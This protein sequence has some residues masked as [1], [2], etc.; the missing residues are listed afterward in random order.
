M[1]KYKGTILIVD[2]DRDV[3]VTARI[4][5][6]D[7]FQSIIVES[8]PKRIPT[9][10]KNEEVY[11]VVLDMNFKPGATSGEE[12]ILWLKKIKE[13]DPG[14]S[15]VMNTAY[16]DIPLAVDAMKHGACEFIVKPWE[17][18]KLVATIK[19]A[20]ELSLSKRE[21]KHLK[22]T[23]KVLS[24]E[25]N[26]E[27]S[28]IFSVSKE[29]KAVFSMINK[30]A[31]TEANVLVLGENGTGKE[32]VAREIHNKSER[33]NKPFINVD[34]GAISTNLFESELFGHEKG[35]FT[36]AKED[37]LGRF[38]IASGGTLFLDEIGNLP[39]ALQ[40][41][42]LSVIQN[43]TINKVGSTKNIETDIRLICATNNDLYS[44]VEKG[45]FRQD[46]L[47]RINTVEINIPPLRERKGDIKLLAEKFLL[48]YSNKYNKPNLKISAKSFS[49]LENY[50]WPGNIRELQHLIE[51]AVILAEEK[52]LHE[53]DF[54]LKPNIK[55]LNSESLKVDE[56][57]KVAIV[58]AIQKHKG[59]LTK[60]SEELGFGRSTLYRKIKKYGI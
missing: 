16:G 11:V 39:V 10:L 22:N 54:A 28:E 34:L 43:K 48:K 57:E 60:A 14:I 15:V 37:K 47:Y 20:Y 12:G 30:V 26:K 45:E 17:C 27:Y 36:D 52:V 5:L 19:T 33:T 8:D 53:N 58:N 23:Q 46:L 51:R 49:A 50:S 25:L 18:A 24:S 44:M 35:A 42:L 2:D 59:N 3:L 31:K 6:K 41:K 4:V 40:S 7:A 1:T 32:L 29:M 9:I 56:L 38:E 13:I 21:V 55:T